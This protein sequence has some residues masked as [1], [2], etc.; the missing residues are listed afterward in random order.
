[1]ISKIYQNISFEELGRFLEIPAAQAELIIA[2]M[3]SENR[4]KAIL[5]QKARIVEFLSSTGNDSKSLNMHTYNS[6][7][8]NVC[9]NLNQLLQE[10]LKKHPEL[11][12]YDTHLF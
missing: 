6:Q 5:D 11:Q 2:S 4:I 10:V 7:I 3:V 1:V 12:K 9:T 8:H